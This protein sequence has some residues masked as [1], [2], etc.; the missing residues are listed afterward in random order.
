MELRAKWQAFDW[1]PVLE[2]TL[3]C[4]G[5]ENASVQHRAEAGVMALM[6]AGMECD[7]PRSIEIFRAIERMVTG[8]GVSHVT[9][10]QARM[11]FNVDH[12]DIHEGVSAASR[13][14][15]EARTG[16]EL[17][18]VFR[19]SLNA[20]MACRV[21]GRF[22]EAENFYHSALELA[23]S[24]GLAFAEQ[25]ALP[26]FAHMALEVGRIDQAKALY[27]KLLRIPEGDFDQLRFIQQRAIGVRLALC[28][29]RSDEALKLLPFSLEDI[30]TDR[31]YSKR[32]YNLALLVAVELSIKGVAPKAATARLEES[33]I[34]AQRT[35]HQAF[36]AFVLHV[37]LRQQGAS[38]KAHRILKDYE[39]KFRREPWPAPRHLLETIEAGLPI[40]HQRKGNSETP[41]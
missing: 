12:G 10:L 2:Q 33:F 20:A 4:L 11:V 37:A 21:A 22:D 18:E 9:E 38:K 39:S 8:G 27:E 13:I 29:Q 32:T 16:N 14:V 15:E 30:S 36:S 25:R 19:S 40:L 6:L 23:T 3:E 5:T 1:H 28:D 31:T 7:R 35:Q 34:K 24:H 17:G 26:M 41:S